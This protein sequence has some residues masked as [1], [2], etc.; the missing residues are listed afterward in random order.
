MSDRDEGVLS[1]RLK[2]LGEEKRAAARK[3]GSIV[4][5][6]RWYYGAWQ[7]LLS[8]EASARLWMFSAML[9]PSGRGSVV[10]DW[11]VLGAM[12]AAVG[13]KQEAL[14]GDTIRTSP[15]AVHKWAWVEPP[16]AEKPS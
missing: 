15:N 10:D 3:S 7:F 4:P 5:T 16:E 9:Y 12:G 2:A 1:R 13:A 14:M 8:Y 6:V 11:A